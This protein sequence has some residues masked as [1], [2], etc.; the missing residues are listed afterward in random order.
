MGPGDRSTLIDRVRIK[1]VGGAGGNGCV[2]FRREKYVPRGGPDGGDGGNGGSV[3]LVANGSVRTLKEMG[4]KRVYRA[5]QGQRGQGSGKH[6]RRGEDVRLG[7]PVGAPVT[8]RGGVRA[9]GGMGAPP[10]AGT[11]PP[12]RAPPGGGRGV[13]DSPFTTLE[14]SL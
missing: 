8:A 9:G 2:S 7:V 12:L 1:V 3:V 11:P 13:P 5:E 6:G 4:R 14:P 10:T